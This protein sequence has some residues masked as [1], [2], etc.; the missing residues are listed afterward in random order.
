MSL[1]GDLN[2][3]KHNNVVKLIAGLL[4]IVCLFAICLS[5]CS[6]LQPAQPSPAS[7][8]DG[9]EVRV[10]V[11]RDFGQKLVFDK[12]VAIDDSTSAMDALKQVAEIETAYSGGFVNAING[13]SSQYKGGSSGDK[14]DWFIYNN[15]I[16]SNVG[17]LDYILHAGDVEHW[18]FHDWSLHAFIP[19][20]IGDFPEPFVHGYDGK[21]HP[22]IV[23]YQN[24]MEE[25]AET[26]AS[27]LSQLEVATISIRSTDSL[28]ESEKESC[29]LVLIGD[30]D[31]EFVSELN[32]VWKRLGF[33]SRFEGGK[34]QVYDPEGGIAAEYGAGSGV[35][36]ATQ[37]PWNPK[38]VGTCENVVWMVSGTDD[39]G[40]GS[41]VD[42]LISRYNEFRYVYAVV[43]AEGEIIKVPQSNH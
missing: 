38:G 43:I 15:G 12:S 42:A 34:L 17:A 26:V 39:V 8:A 10:V 33:F 20:I 25:Y 32:Q 11:T 24:G 37:S 31:C 29:N 30:M 3:V 41:A 18:D 1:K 40:V 4:F 21:V 23:V 7:P 28:L 2:Q 16:L 13:L 9:A 27:K 6:D 5:G 19:A 22:T 36:Q 14:K 35:I